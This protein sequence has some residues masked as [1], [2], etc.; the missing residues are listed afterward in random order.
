ME[1]TLGELIDRLCITNLKMW[2]IE[3][4]LLDCTID[5]V[6]KGRLCEDI[7]KLNNLRADCI[8]SINEYFDRMKKHE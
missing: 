7:V 2:H 8:K 3:E 1:Y 6:T 5:M 4:Q